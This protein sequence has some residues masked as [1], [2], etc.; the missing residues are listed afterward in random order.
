MPKTVILARR[1]V[2]AASAQ[3]YRKDSILSQEPPHSCLALP[4]AT[5]NEGVPVDPPVDAHK[6]PKTGILARRTVSA[7][8][9]QTYR[10]DSILSQ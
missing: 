9:A 10:K 3:T 5:M 2:S 4:G 6:M 8:G 7:A 1:T